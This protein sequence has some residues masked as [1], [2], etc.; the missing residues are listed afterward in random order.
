M[1]AA[2]AAVVLALMPQP[3]AADD[4]DAV[5]RGRTAG[6]GV[7]IV[8]D[9]LACGVALLKARCSAAVD[10]FLQRHGQADADYK[11]VP[12]IGPHPAT[13]LRAFIGGDREAMDFALEWFNTAQSTE[14]LWT[15]DARAAAIYDAGVM[16][17][18][19]PAARGYPPFESVAIAGPVGDLANHA[20]LIPAGTLPVDLGPIRAAANLDTTPSK[21]G[22]TLYQRRMRLPPGASRFAHDV[23]AKLDTAMPSPPFATMAYTDDAAGDAALGVAAAT[24]RE[25]SE[26]PG[27]WLVQPDVQ[28]FIDLYV[29]RLRAVAPER[30]SD[31]A[32]LREKLRG[33]AVTDFAEMQ[34]AHTR[35]LGA[36]FGSPTARAQR[37]AV[38][39]AA[40][41]IPYN[42]MIVRDEKA[43]VALL[44]VVGRSDEFDMI[45]GFANARAEAK[46]LAPANWTAQYK[47]GLRLVDL[48][49]KGGPN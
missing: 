5:E 10:A 18:L 9:P 6:R 44:G 19:L 40:A 13:G 4:R 37:A 46:N 38:A 29:A 20:A 41:Q 24:V 11:S 26:I 35:L 45:P 43:A 48:L 15:E 36:V 39:F 21:V 17:V 7:L 16:D 1:A 49:T 42:A 2:L 30:A 32:A 27:Y 33:A 14:Q 34:A 8:R 22:E 31:I 3:A 25:L 28:S 23:V 47:L 12:H